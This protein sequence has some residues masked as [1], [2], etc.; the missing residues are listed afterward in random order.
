MRF[1]LGSN[2]YIIA[3]L[4]SV[5]RNV[6]RHDSFRYPV[7]HFV[8][9]EKEVE[10]ILNFCQ[11]QSSKDQLLL[12]YGMPGVGKSELIQHALNTLTQTTPGVDIIK[13]IFTVRKGTTPWGLEDIAANILEEIQPDQLYINFRVAALHKILVTIEKP[14]LLVLEM[15]ALDLKKDS[16]MVVWSFL[17][18]LLRSA[19]QNLKLIVTSYKSPDVSLLQSFHMEE[20]QLKGL[21]QTEAFKLLRG[22]NPR[23][24]RMNC[25]RI[26]ERCGS[27][28]FILR[29]IGAH[30]KNFHSNEKELEAF[31]K[32][33]GSK[34]QL[35]VLQ[36]MLA[37]PMI[38]HNMKVVFKELEEAEQKTLVKLCG[39]PEIIPVDAINHIFGSTLYHSCNHLCMNHCII[40]KSKSGVYFK[41]SV[42][43]RTFIKDFA[44]S[45]ITLNQ[46]LNDSREKVIRYYLNMAKSLDE[47]YHH[48]NVLEKRDTCFQLVSIYRNSCNICAED[49]FCPTMKIV[50]YL[51]RLRKT[52]IM[53]AFQQGLQ[54][55]DLF[56]ETVQTCLKVVH[57]LRYV[58]C[59][60]DLLE[61]Y[62]EIFM[63]LETMQ[64]KVLMAMTMAN[65]VFVKVYAKVGECREE[66]I[67]YLSKAIKLLEHSQLF[68]GVTETLIHCYLKRGYLYSFNPSTFYQAMADIKKA[69]IT[70]LNLSSTK[71]RQLMDMVVYGYFSGYKSLIM[72]FNFNLIH[73][74]K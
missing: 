22:M 23:M 38:K 58:I 70:I 49:C 1:T 33:L 46:I 64:E 29:T 50:K 69:K 53:R 71:E 18:S 48:P 11:S 5:R 39:F 42:L 40:E 62:D 68:I 4:F 17:T 7:L 30:I 25:Q 12:L 36:P 59:Y 41:M 66:N 14:T 21:S 26:F 8:G 6:K 35:E 45:N 2:Y 55:K 37:T 67:L 73:N 60:E 27:H 19:N 72:S 47:I 52:L 74:D 32:D 24:K 51:F 43:T 44:E 10:R 54:T 3:F 15:C 61:L 31:I 65:L 20:I 57:F 13:P 34:S 16:L 63:K 28:P 9:R 56:Y